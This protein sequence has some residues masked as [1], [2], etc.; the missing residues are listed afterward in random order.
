VSYI[1]IAVAVETRSTVKP[2]TYARTAI[3][4]GLSY[5]CRRPSA[6]VT[7]PLKKFL[8]P[9]RDPDQHR[10][11]I[12]ASK[13]SHT[14]SENLIKIIYSFSIYRQNSYNCPRPEMEFQAPLRGRNHHPHLIVIVTLTH[15]LK[16]KGEGSSLDIAPLT[17]LDSGA[18]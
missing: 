10:N 14:L 1:I 9:D 15:T 7:I 3:V 12:V 11:Q 18:L 6:V 5:S 4:P 13:T 16:V 2:Q 8:D 17:I